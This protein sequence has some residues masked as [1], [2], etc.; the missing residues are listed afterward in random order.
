MTGKVTAS[1]QTVFDHSHYLRLIEARGET[2]RRLVSEL[3]PVLSLA[4]A[5]DAGCGL[6][7]FAKI[8]RD[9]GLDVHGFDGRLENVEEAR[10]RFPGISFQQGDA[11][12]VEIR[13]LGRFDLVLCFGLLYHLEN[14]MSAIRNLH[15][16]TGKCLLVESMCFPD[17]EPWML[18]RE[19]RPL[20]DQSLTDIAFYASEGCLVKM[21]YRAGFSAVYRVA[22]LPDHDDF[23]DTADH[24]RRRTVLLALPQK[25]NMS[26]LTFISEPRESPDPWQK[27]PSARAKIS[28]RVQQFI[29]RP[30]DERLASIRRRV[31]RLLGE[32]PKSITLPFGA[33]WLL[34]GSELDHSLAKGDF[35]SAETCFV[36]RLLRPGM[37]A[38]DVGAHHGYY[39][40]LASTLVGSQGRV[41]AFEPSPRERIRLERHVRINKCTNVQIEPLALASEKSRA[42]LYLVEGSEDYCNSLRPPAVR[43]PTKTVP[44]EVTSLQEFLSHQRMGP[45]DFIK[46]DV[47][48]A[49]LE[50]LKGAGEALQNQPRPV[51]MVEV[52]ESRTEP[53]GYRSR[54]IV[55]LLSKAGYDWFSLL[56][57]GTPQS[58]EPGLDRYDANLVAVPRESVQ[59]FLDSFRVRT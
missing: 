53:W 7:F 4:T 30:A 51:L 41:I 59:S 55:Q 39:T 47:E 14:P 17:E 10:R 36:E 23:C 46:L 8:L 37:T 26:G 40:L 32:N 34:E 16:L 50:V 27:T 9:A 15:A 21:L 35:E 43:S 12:S 56:N 38:L 45:I 54:E 19:E 29:A 3:K 22:S 58:I 48:G 25:M 13:S 44:V 18:L 57:D 2:I 42:D 5:L 49:E 33:R 52:Y 1:P 31:R 24:E 6:G 11:Q 20:E 28:K